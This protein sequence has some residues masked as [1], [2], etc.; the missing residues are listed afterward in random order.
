MPLVALSLPVDH[1]GRRM[2]QALLSRAKAIRMCPKPQ[3]Y[4]SSVTCPCKSAQPIPTLAIDPGSS[5]VYPRISLQP[6]PAT[7]SRLP[8]MVVPVQLVPG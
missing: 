7:V 4:T 1:K 5:M 8:A 2:R 3:T 6:A